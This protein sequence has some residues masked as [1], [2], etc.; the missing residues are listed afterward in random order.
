MTDHN[1]D[2]VPSIELVK[3]EATNRDIP[4][5]LRYPYPTRRESA[6]A[7]CVNEGF[8]MLYERITDL[9][10]QVGVMGIALGSL[11][12]KPESLAAA[13]ESVREK[14][15]EKINKASSGSDSAE[16]AS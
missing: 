7:D 3:E 8:K 12:I 11:G 16:D 5:Q 1:V 13:A 15:K 9:E 2:G 14:V 6:L 4:Y 10:I